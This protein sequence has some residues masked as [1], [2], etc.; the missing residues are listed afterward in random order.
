[1]TSARSRTRV[2]LRAFAGLVGVAVVSLWHRVLRAAVGPPPPAPRSAPADAVVFEHDCSWRRYLR[3]L[4]AHHGPDGDPSRRPETGSLLVGLAAWPGTR[5]LRGYTL[6]D[7][8]YLAPG[9][10]TVV[11]VHQAGHAPA[12]GREQPTL[13]RDRRADGGLPD[14]PLRTFDVM[15]PGDLPHTACRLRDPR[16]L[17]EEYRAW[18]HDGRIARVGGCR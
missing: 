14:A 10:P 6:G 5:F 7:H 1:M 9:A 4:A 16:G 18:L 8:V 17:R 11:R 2:A 15:L 3:A 12:F 13:A